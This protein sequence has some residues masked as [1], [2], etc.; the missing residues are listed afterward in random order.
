MSVRILH[1]ADIHIDAPLRF[2]GD[3]GK[4]QRAQIF[5]T[6][7]AVLN[8]A[9][10]HDILLIAGDLFDSNFVSQPTLDKVVTGLKSLGIPVVIL[11]GT[12]DCIGASSIYNREDWKRGENI[13][14]FREEKPHSFCFPEL[15]LCIQ[16]KATIK[17]SNLSPLAGLVKSPDYQYNIAMAH[18]SVTTHSLILEDT[19]CPINVNDISDSRMDYIA[20]GH[21]HSW[22]QAAEN[23]LY[24]GSPELVKFGQSSTAIASIK[25]DDQ[26]CEIERIDIGKRKSLER[27]I[28]FDSLDSA[29]DIIRE[30]E[31]LSDDDAAAR[32]TIAGL[33]KAG[34]LID[35]SDLEEKLKNRFF[36]LELRDETHPKVDAESL[37]A[38]SR[39]VMGRF[40]SIMRKKIDS[41]PES[42][43]KLYED[44]LQV[45][46]ALLQG[47]KVLN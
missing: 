7:E 44:A 15:D 43:R 12:H 10:N 6:F 21:W 41:V 36:F 42:E 16:G 26:G 28:S 39:T 5:R 29:D 37:Q 23:A 35:I 47:K 24:P 33:T 25:L 45:G 22:Y 13:F 19:A 27:T 1:T 32:I 9:K 8:T 11:P 14:I 3:K 31:H 30:I 34:F 4:E 18:G 40:I 2:L 17:D 38:D 46:I 20:L